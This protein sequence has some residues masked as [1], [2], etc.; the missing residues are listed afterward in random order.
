MKRASK[1]HGLMR[2]IAL[3]ALTSHIAFAA[4]ATAQENVQED[5]SVER[6]MSEPVGAA[7]LTAQECLDADNTRCV[8]NT[9]TPLLGQGLNSYEQMVILRLRAVAYYNQEQLDLAIRDLEA[10]IA[11]GAATPDEITALRISLGQLYIVSGRYSEGIAEL[12]A[13]IAEGVTPSLAMLLAQAYAQ[14]E[15]WEE[16]LVYARMQFDMIEPRERRSFDL[17]LLY[18]Q[19]LDR[20]SE[21]L[22]LIGQMVERWPDDRGLW[23][24][25]I[26]ALAHANDDAGAFEAHKLMYLN[27]MLTEESELIRLVQYYSDF[28]YPYRGAVIL[29]R[30]M[31]AG[32]VSRSPE[33]LEILASMW[34]QSREYENAI[35]T[36]EV[37]AQQGD[38][39]DYLRLGEAYYH[40]N[41]LP[42]AE[43][44]FSRAIESGGLSRE[45]DA[46]ALLGTVRYELDNREGALDAFRHC[47]QFDYSRRTCEGWRRFLENEVQPVI[48]HPSLRER[49]ATEECRI[50]IQSDLAIDT[51]ET[52]VWT[53]D[54]EGRAIIEIP[55][56]C[57]EYFNIHG[58]QIGGH[59]FEQTEI[60]T[61]SDAGA[62]ERF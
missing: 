49:V 17:L 19:Q 62:P 45:G 33:N 52:D 32:R 13:A 26:A 59:G 6:A 29:E 43:Q 38:G 18:V 61:E 36:F 55:E 37:L 2:L 11:T 4:E 21:A 25:L 30:E 12:E 56:R 54:G 3:L 27:G 23:R 51:L 24:S 31:N 20:D 39:E 53:F 28:E 46:F 9:L 34:R 44:A 41:R 10:A 14:A 16:G 7:I 48:D 5:R 58:E 15:R 47:E 57:R 1:T 22:E 60:E 42:D 35:S 40:V 50:A 8:I